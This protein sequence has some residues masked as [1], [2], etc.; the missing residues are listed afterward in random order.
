[1]W[2]DAVF[3]L[4]DTAGKFFDVIVIEYGDAALDNPWA[5]VEFLSDQVNGAAVLA[6]AVVE[7]ALV[8]VQAWVFR[9]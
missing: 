3:D 6:L 1:M 5:A 2:I 9:Q 8:R 4:E 7:R